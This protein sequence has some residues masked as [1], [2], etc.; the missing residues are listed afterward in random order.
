[1][2]NVFLDEE[3]KERLT[4][5]L[6]EMQVKEKSLMTYSGAVSRLLDL[7]KKQEVKQ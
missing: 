5:A 3:T 6:T 4:E 2:A 7:Y 1:M